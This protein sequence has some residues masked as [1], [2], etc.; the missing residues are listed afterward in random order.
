MHR[1]VPTNKELTSLVC[2]RAE[3][4]DPD[5]KD[6]LWGWESIENTERV[7]SKV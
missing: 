6:H 3:V 7:V 5:V 2:N 4:E 1:K